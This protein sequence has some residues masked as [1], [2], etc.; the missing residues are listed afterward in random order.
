M[1][2]Q[3]TNI[4]ISMFWS[5]N[6]HLRWNSFI[7]PQRD[8]KFSVHCIIKNLQQFP[9]LREGCVLWNFMQVEFYISQ[10]FPTFYSN[11]FLSHAHGKLQKCALK[12]TI[13][14]SKTSASTKENI[15]YPFISYGMQNTFPWFFLSLH[16]LAKIYASGVL[17]KSGSYCI[18]ATWEW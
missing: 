16:W 2:L 9:N 18:C 7:N 15:I 1:H 11:F 12:C 3:I 13:K 4:T 8:F 14:R 5:S 10:N 6:D 17:L